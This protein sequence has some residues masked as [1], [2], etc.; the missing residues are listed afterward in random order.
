MEG[1][2]HEAVFQ[3]YRANH[4]LDGWVGIVFLSKDVSDVYVQSEMSGFNRCEEERS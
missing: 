3:F 1:V 2:S 4:L